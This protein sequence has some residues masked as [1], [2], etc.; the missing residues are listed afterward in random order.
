MKCRTCAGDLEKQG[1]PTDLA[2][3]ATHIA[4]AGKNEWPVCQEHI[5]LA[6]VADW[7]PITR[8]KKEGDA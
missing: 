6:M 1:M 7:F 8:I 5:Q 3:E 2:T 4:M